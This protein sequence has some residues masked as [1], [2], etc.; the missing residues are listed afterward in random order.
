M[1]HRSFFSILTMRLYTSRDIHEFEQAAISLAQPAGK[2]LVPLVKDGI[3]RYVTNIRTDMQLLQMDEHVL[4]IALQKWN[5]DDSLIASPSTLYFDV[6]RDVIEDFNSLSLRLSCRAPLEIAKPLFRACRFNSVVLVNGWPFSTTLYPRLSSTQVAKIRSFL[7]REFPH[8]PIVFRTVDKLSQSD[9]HEIFRSL[10]FRLVYARPIYYM[11]PHSSEFKL[12]KSLKRDLRQVRR[13]KYE[14]VGTS[15]LRDK[16]IPRM[17]DLY[18]R[19][20]ILKHSRHNPNYTMDFFRLLVKDDIM[21]IIALR[22]KGRIDAF[23]GILEDKRMMTSPFLGYD[24]NAPKELALYRIL[25][26]LLYLR[27][28]DRGLIL[29]NSAG[30]AYFKQTRGCL[31]S[32]E[33]FAVYDQHLPLYRKLPWILL[34]AANCVAI[35]IMRKYDS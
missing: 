34:Q 21:P 19:L 7:V 12:T 28:K 33:Y 32:M 13:T 9:F 18:R 27:A 30:V 2:L 11:F 16:D 22:K 6:A 5:Q 35:P 29:N 20:Y 31:F 4:P 10:G 3:Q 8:H 1:L 15:D 17:Y 14:I 25:E 24:L 23:L 26:S